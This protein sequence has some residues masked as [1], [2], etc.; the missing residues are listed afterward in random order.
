[1][2]SID[3]LLTEIL[4]SYEKVGGI[5]LDGVNQFPNREAVIRLLKDLQALVFPGFF[6]RRN[7]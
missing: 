4:D 6:N 2:K 1:M 7:S 5:N 3:T